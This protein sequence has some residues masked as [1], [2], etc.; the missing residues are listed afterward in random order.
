MPLDLNALEINSLSERSQVEGSAVIKLLMH[1]NSAA[2]TVHEI[3]STKEALAVRLEAV[4]A[5]PGQKHLIVLHVNVLDRGYDGVTNHYVGMMIEKTEGG[6]AGRYNI[7]YRDPMGRDAH[8]GIKAIIEEKLEQI[9][10]GF[11]KGRLQY[12]EVVGA[13]AVKLFAEGSNDYDCGPILVLLM[14]KVASEKPAPELTGGS[15]VIRKVASKNIGA[16]LREIFR[17]DNG[18]TADGSCKLADYDIQEVIAPIIAYK[19]KAPEAVVAEKPA[20][21]RVERNVSAADTNSIAADL[22][23]DNETEGEDVKQELSI[24]HR[25]KELRERLKDLVIKESSIFL[26]KDRSESDK[27]KQEI[28]RVFLELGALYLEEVEVVGVVKNASKLNEGVMFANYAKSIAE[29]FLIENSASSEVVGGFEEILALA[30]DNMERT[31]AKLF[32]VLKAQKPEP[33]SS[34]IAKDKEQLK[35]I[36][37]YC[38]NKLKE[39]EIEYE[40]IKKDGARVAVGVGAGES[41]ESEEEVNLKAAE[42]YEIKEVRALYKHIAKETKG[43]LANIIKECEEILGLPPCKYSVIGLGSLALN[44]FTPY[45]DLEFAILMEDSFDENRYAAERELIALTTRGS[46]L[47]E[48]KDRV[49]AL[50]KGRR[51]ALET[52]ERNKQYF[53]N[54]TQLIHFRVLNLGETVIPYSKFELPLDQYTRR[55]ISFDLGGKTPLGRLDKPQYELIQ[56]PYRMARYLKHV[57]SKV[58][59]NLPTILDSVVHITGDDAITASYQVLVKQYFYAIDPETGE[60]NHQVKAYKRL[61]EGLDEVDY[62]G[63]TILN[64]IRS[65]VKGDI[66][67]FKPKLAKDIDDGRLFDVKQ[68]VYRLPDRLLYDLATYFGFI[69]KS[70]WDAVNQLQVNHIISES[71]SASYLLMMVTYAMSLRLRTYS[72]YGEQNELS[73]GLESVELP[74]TVITATNSLFRLSN[75]EL[76]ENGKLFR[77]YYTAISFHQIVSSSFTGSAINSVNDNLFKISVFCIND[78]KTRGIIHK[79][80]LRYEMARV[81]LEEAREKNP[82]DI[83]TIGLL[84]SVFYKLTKYDKAMQNYDKALKLCDESDLKELHPYIIPLL[85][86][87]T[88]VY[89]SLGEHEQGIKFAERALAICETNYPNHTNLARAL[90]ALAATCAKKD[91]EAALK[92]EMRALNKQKEL[93]PKLHPDIALAVHNIGFTLWRL[94][95]NAEAIDYFLEALYIRERYYRDQNNP[96]IAQVLNNVGVAYEKLEKFDI[97]LGYKLRSLKMRKI[98]YPDGKNE[99]IALVLSGIGDVYRRLKKHAES[100]QYYEGSLGLRRL[101]YIGEDKY[102]IADSLMNVG[103]ANTSLEKL[104]DSL[105]NFIDAHDMFVKLNKPGCVDSKRIQDKLQLLERI[106]NRQVFRQLELPFDESVKTIELIANEKYGKALNYKYSGSLIFSASVTSDFAYIANE[107]QEPGQSRPLLI[108]GSR[109]L[110]FFDSH[111]ELT[112]GINF[113]DI[114]KKFGIDVTAMT[115]R[116][117]EERSRHRGI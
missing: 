26:E 51:E 112:E 36:R 102:D 37:E 107:L 17:A 57:W 108:K 6:A 80:L 109:I 34:K 64:P 76:E 20:V 32:E 101:I 61:K 42:E 44:Q 40:R 74:A 9:E 67:T 52:N 65:N 38:K 55:G 50:E 94:N 68:E 8:D 105:K 21:V 75:E 83:E 91:P 47:L 71:G 98:L 30:V 62:L 92:Y 117:K 88:W 111:K 95:R 114:V 58:D 104:S 19:P 63:A 33:M 16:R 48:A 70:A 60:P 46:E 84:G 35:S 106:I 5:N 86:D 115:A 1:Y 99:K 22:L 18:K 23:V 87:I 7:Q 79:R 78:V 11:Y 2:A 53:R 73:T 25:E 15:E 3:A 69:P 29:S 90:I 116:A 97:A 59:K 113:V 43:L 96:L 10:F 54:L 100:K 93:L 49:V 24:S 56:T 41:K 39:I 28:A 82:D 31:Q 66:E 77:F 13:S 27:K 12:A 45:S 14:T 72:Y 103:Y 89:C 81:R 4:K 110:L 85:V